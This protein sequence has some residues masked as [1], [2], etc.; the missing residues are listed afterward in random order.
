LL[1]GIVGIKKAIINT[2][3]SDDRLHPPR[4]PYDLVRAKIEAGS[5]PEESCRAPGN[6]R[7]SASRLTRTC[8]HRSFR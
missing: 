4:S 6:A 1:L 8:L 3:H 7:L 2:V 5:L